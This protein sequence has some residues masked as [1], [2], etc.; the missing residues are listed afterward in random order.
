[1]VGTGLIQVDNQVFVVFLGKINF[2]DIF[3]IF[4]IKS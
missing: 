4:L 3:W 2:R 1:M